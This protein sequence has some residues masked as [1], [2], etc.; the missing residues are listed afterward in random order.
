MENKDCKKRKKF[1]EL[2]HDI[3]T[4]VFQFLDFKDLFLM[5]KVSKLWK[6]VV[7]QEILWKNRMIY[8]ESQEQDICG[9]HLARFYRDVI[10]SI[11]PFSLKNC[12]GLKKLVLKEKM[13][14]KLLDTILSNNTCLEHLDL[15]FNEL[16]PFENMKTYKL[17]NLK[18]LRTNT[19]EL[20]SRIKTN[21]LEIFLLTTLV[22]HQDHHKMLY[23]F[24]IQ[25][26]NLSV[27]SVSLEEYQQRDI[28]ENLTKLKKI[29][30]HFFHYS[31]LNT[32]K[33]LSNL[34]VISFTETD[35]DNYQF[36]ELMAFVQARDIKGLDIG[37]YDYEL[38]F[39]IK[40][41]SIEHLKLA[42]WDPKWI[43]ICPNLISLSVITLSKMYC[44]LEIIKHFP[45]LE[46][47]EFDY[48]EYPDLTKKVE[49]YKEKQFLIMSGVKKLKFYASIRP[50]C[51]YV[52]LA[53]CPFLS[54]DYRVFKGHDFSNILFESDPFKEL[55][56]SLI[57][58]LKYVIQDQLQIHQ[59]SEKI[60]D[61]L[62]R[63]KSSID[64]G[65][66]DIK[67]CNEYDLS[68]YQFL[69]FIKR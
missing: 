65:V 24:T 31:Y 47:F 17:Q 37:C 35:M 12:T 15:N 33:N 41:E 14:A 58:S 50:E 42:Y 38:S 2:F 39:Q 68:L 28:L 1:L 9:N 4:E 30:F 21:S 18:F 23:D 3:L 22:V 54:I 20:I 13:N 59:T 53:C 8:I 48:D 63:V 45:K 10:S 6:K 57:I 16:E 11:I 51:I 69:S 27:V 25:Q 44:P 60:K 19:I 43:K 26:K 29:E 32:L 66:K 7:N 46:T 62:S 36:K 5:E 56:Q 52:L 61:S 49:F 34:E 64:N 67:V 55:E 40:C